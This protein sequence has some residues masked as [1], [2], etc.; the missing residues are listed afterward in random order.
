MAIKPVG[1]YY[2]GSTLPATVKKPAVPA[3]KPVTYSGPSNFQTGY[4]PG[5]VPRSA[6][7]QTYGG[8]TY[9]LPG[10]DTSAITGG[11]VVGGAPGNQVLTRTTTTNPFVGDIT[12][13]PDYQSGAVR[14]QTSLDALRTA[15]REANQNA[16]IAGGFQI[17]PSRFTGQAAQFASDVDPTTL[18]AAAQNQFS[19]R[20]GIER[21]LNQGLTQ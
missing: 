12:S 17:D 14:R 15:L 8:S 18:A 21:A 1:Y 16:I 11:D 7:Y 20:A 2:G 19:T 4:Q 5:A 13:E 10:L 3:L 9:A 6:G